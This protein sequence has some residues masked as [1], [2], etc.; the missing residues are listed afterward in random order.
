MDAATCA[1]RTH[2]VGAKTYERIVQAFPGKTRSGFITQGI[3]KAISSEMP[4]ITIL[5]DTSRE[6]S[7]MDCSKLVSVLWGVVKELENQV[8]A[9]ATSVALLSQPAS[10]DLLS[11]P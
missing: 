8:Q 1:E 9:F 4:D 3:H 11:C 2:N 6:L 7:S 10:S 5:V